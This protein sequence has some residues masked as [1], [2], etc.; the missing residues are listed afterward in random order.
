MTKAINAPG[1]TATAVATA[2]MKT[3]KVRYSDEEL[4]EFKNNILKKLK[5]A[6]EDL[7]FL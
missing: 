6:E 2:T 7:N 5:R 3:C 4:Q 1:K